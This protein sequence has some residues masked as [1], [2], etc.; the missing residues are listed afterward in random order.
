MKKWNESY[1]T[2]SADNKQVLRQYLSILLLF[3][4]GEQKFNHMMSS[5][6]EWRALKKFLDLNDEGA[7]DLRFVLRGLLSRVAE[8]KRAYGEAYEQG[9]EVGFVVRGK[10]IKPKKMFE[11]FMG[12]IPEV[13]NKEI[14]GTLIFV[15]GAYNMFLYVDVDT[16]NIDI[17][18]NRH[19]K[20]LGFNI[21]YEDAFMIGD[22][23]R[24]SGPLT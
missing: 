5:V 3:F 17:A 12:K 20:K 15:V 6:T 19:V 22:L 10:E 24:A 21:Q 23:A 18:N 14:L 2:L 16:G 4:N 11:D 7:E 9:N 8:F 13:S 1:S